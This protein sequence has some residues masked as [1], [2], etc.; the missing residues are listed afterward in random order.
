MITFLCPNGHKLSSPEKLAGKAG[1]CPNCGVRFRIPGGEAAPEA[2]PEVTSPIVP[3][4]DQGPPQ[5]VFLCPNGHRL[6]GPHSLAGK[7]GQCPHCGSKF[8]IPPIT[9]EG[10]AVVTGEVA[11][12]EIPPAPA[13]AEPEIP[14]EAIEEVAE[15]PAETPVAGEPA[16]AVGEVDLDFAALEQLVQLSHGPTDARETAHGEVHPIAALFEQLWGERG[17]DSLVELQLASGE[18]VVPHFYAAERSR[19]NCAFFA[20]REEDGKHT[21]MAIPWETVSRVTIRGVPELPGGF[22]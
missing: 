9:E 21:L 16:P 14:L 10:P 6:H 7:A 20:V 22:S 15:E 5:I 11:T 2:P 1:Q 18:T 8:R 13:V 19:R 17:S 4:P 3:A 12:V